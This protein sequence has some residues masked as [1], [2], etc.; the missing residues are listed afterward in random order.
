MSEK[1]LT[2]DSKFSLTIKELIAA[3]VGFSSLIAMYFTLQADIAKAMELPEPEVQKI[4]FDYKDQLVRKTIELTQEDVSTIKS[5]IE[6]IKA[7]LNKMDERLY[8][9]SRK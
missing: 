6:E 5:D 2:P 7:Q 3:A 9:I 1:S 8:E 4:E